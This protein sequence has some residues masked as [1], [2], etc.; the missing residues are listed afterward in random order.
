MGVILSAKEA[1]I[2]REN[3]V[4]ID[5][6]SIKDQIDAAAQIIKNKIKRNSKYKNHKISIFAGSGKKGAIGVA[7]A[8]QLDQED[9]DV[10]LYIIYRNNK[11][12]EYTESYR[13]D[14]KKS[15]IRYSDVYDKMHLHKINAQYELVIDAILGDSIKT[16]PSKGI[17]ALI[18]YI[19]SS[20]ADVISIDIPSGLFAE[21][22]SGLNPDYIIRAKE[23]YVIDEAK[24]AIFLSENKDFVGKYSI[25]DIGIS[26]KS[27]ENINSIYK[28]SSEMTTSNII[29]SI[30]MSKLKDEKLSIISDSRALGLASLS[31]Q[32]AIYSGNK[33]IQL[34]AKPDKISNFQIEYPEIELM[35]VSKID[36]NLA[37][38]LGTI[39]AVSL[40][41]VNQEEKASY[42]GF[43]R[44]YQ[45][46][47]VYCSSAIKELISKDGYML[48]ELL[49][50]GDIIVTNRSEA[51]IL[52]IQGIT[53]YEIINEALRISKLYNIYI[54]LYLD[55]TMVCMPSGNILINDKPNIDILNEECSMA[56]LNTMIANFV[57]KG[58]SSATASIISSYAFCKAQE[59]AFTDIRSKNMRAGELLERIRDSFR[60]LEA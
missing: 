33:K 14:L 23:T 5:K 29:A 3:A 42:L 47:S 10:S 37:L 36:M 11:V 19:N 15:G 7:L 46:F 43:M 22:S 45:G 54:V 30:K 17:S 40:S 34:L 49:R 35:P 2:V 50:V 48:N 1:S 53:D 32:S 52:G 12:S 28:I 57:S 4:H 25:I 27:K 24:L 26:A 21:N 44:S 58:L 20:K 38:S 31:I 56:I 39:S 6:L 55:Y 16:P 51:S 41:F 60:I 13:E 59:L 18:K 9:Y 8:L